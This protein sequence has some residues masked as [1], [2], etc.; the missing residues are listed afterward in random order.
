MAGTIL[1]VDD[2]PD[3]LNVTA[4]S[5]GYLGY[6]IIPVYDAEAAMAALEKTIPNLILMDLMLPTMHGD[7]LCRRLK[8]DERYCHIPVILFTAS[9][10][11]HDLPKMIKNTHADDVLVKPFRPEELKAKVKKLIS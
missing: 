9:N 11:S 4:T 10:L 3:I 2:E 1:I 5:L 6:R 7:E 8:S